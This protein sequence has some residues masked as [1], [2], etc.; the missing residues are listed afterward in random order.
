MVKVVPAETM[1]LL[2]KWLLRWKYTTLTT[3]ANTEALQGI[4]K[5]NWQSTDLNTSTSIH[6]CL[7]I[8]V[9]FITSSFY[10]KLL[11]LHINLEKSHSVMLP[12][13]IV[14]ETWTHFIHICKY[15]GGVKFL[16]HTSYIQLFIILQFE[17]P[18]TQSDES[19]NYSFSVAQ[20]KFS[21]GLSQWVCDSLTFFPPPFSA[22]AQ[23]ERCKRVL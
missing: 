10:S 12:D 2:V 23:T 13:A 3:S 6:T 19:F 5:R 21:R 8:P 22:N 20:T 18:P 16:T 7:I 1:L 4:S 14:M 17:N 11:G 9:P 15:W